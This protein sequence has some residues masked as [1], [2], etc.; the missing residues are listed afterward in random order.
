MVSTDGLLQL[1][2]EVGGKGVRIQDVL[3]G[4]QASVLLLL[5]IVPIRSLVFGLPAFPTLT[6]ALL[7]W[8]VMVPACFGTLYLRAS[9]WPTAVVMRGTSTLIALNFTALFFDLLIWQQSGVPIPHEY[10]AL[11]FVGLLSVD[12][13]PGRYTLALCGLFLGLNLTAMQ[14]IHGWT[15]AAG[16]PPPPNWKYSCPCLLNWTRCTL[17]LLV[18]PLSGTKD[19]TK[20][21][22]RSIPATFLLGKD[23]RLV[24]TDTHGDKLEAALQKLLGE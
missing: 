6:T 14:M 13:L 23:G 9:T 21:N 7:E 5:A 15:P 16:C 11:C 1:Q 12:G 20:Y 10:T 17:S 4:A 8:G 2:Q 22:I 19:G 18:T 3:P 24:T